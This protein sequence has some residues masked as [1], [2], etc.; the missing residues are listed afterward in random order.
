M[1][2]SLA[3]CMFLCLAALSE[4]ARASDAFPLL[5]RFDVSLDG[6]F[7]E[8]ADQ[9]IH[10][11][12]TFPLPQAGT[13]VIIGFEPL[14]SSNVHHMLL[15][16]NGSPWASRRSD[17]E[18]WAWAHGGTPF[19]LPPNMG[20]VVFRDK[21]YKVNVNVH[22][23]E[24]NKRFPDYSGV[25]LLYVVLTDE[26]LTQYKPVTIWTLIPQKVFS[27]SSKG[28]EDEF[29]A[30]G[31]QLVSAV[32]RPADE[33]LQVFAYRVHAH[34]HSKVN[35]VTNGVKTL[36]RSPQL[37]QSF[38]PLPYVFRTGSLRG[39]T[40]GDGQSSETPFNVRKGE[41][42]TFSCIYD[43][44]KL[45]THEVVEEGMKN[46]Q[47]MCNVYL[48]HYPITLDPRTTS[49]TTESE[50]ERVGGRTY[51]STT[52][53]GFEYERANSAGVVADGDEPEPGDEYEKEYEKT[54]DKKKE[55]VS[56][57][58]EA[59]GRID[60]GFEVGADLKKTQL[61]G[62]DFDEVNERLIIVHRGD[63][64]WDANTFA[65][66]NV[67]AAFSEKRT[68]EA[69]S[70]DP[71]VMLD[72]LTGER[73]SSYGG[74][75]FYLPHSIRFDPND[76]DVVW[77]VDLALHSVV[78]FSLSKNAPIG[79]LNAKTSD[80]VTG[81]GLNEFCQPTDLDFVP[82]SDDLIVSDGYCNSRVVVFSRDRVA[83][84]AFGT[85]GS[86]AE[87][88]SEPEERV[89]DMQ[90]VHS[91]AHDEIPQ[92]GHVDVAWVA[93]RES[94]RLHLFTIDG[95]LLHSFTFSS[96]FEHMKYKAGKLFAVGVKNADELILALVK[97]GLSEKKRDGAMVTFRKPDL[98][99]YV[100]NPGGFTRAEDLSTIIYDGL[101]E[102]HLLALG[103]GVAYVAE[104]FDGARLGN[105]HRVLL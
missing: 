5:K 92:C 18:L 67:Y 49:P 104:A 16:A 90:V 94:A 31:E 93:D 101:G 66:D 47:E 45:A 68:L 44:S 2:L 33:D 17:D 20:F 27:L 24:R 56:D 91:V 69:I 39:A 73:K 55:G 52:D 59:T 79:K 70:V 13:P 60:A 53:V 29:T 15:S 82:S 8:M 81:D 9:Y 63:R 1:M 96:Y 72:P 105:L 46:D 64:I 77:V 76:E 34:G 41:T 62:V 84:H 58:P 71:I 88:V 99:A 75:F 85:S 40:E 35:R 37:A 95:L 23:R 22:F 3:T 36:K 80:F 11:T 74:G 61:V 87:G 19:R 102:P 89:K 57:V 103:N 83:R 30:R 28:D 6:A 48:M 50:S 10:R 98:C 12:V 38:N 54:F 100:K 4:L 65:D 78:E 26:E 7:V 42:L 97:E 14:A 25:R 32:S 86:S 51:G 21:P 43:I